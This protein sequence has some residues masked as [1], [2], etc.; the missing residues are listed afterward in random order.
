MLSQDVIR[1]MHVV[2]TE[3][4]LSSVD[5]KLKSIDRSYDQIVAGSTRAAS[6]TD[7]AHRRMVASF[8]RGG[9]GGVGGMVAGDATAFAARNIA[10]F[11]VAAGG[12]YAAIAAV[13]AV[14]ERGSELLEKYAN[15]QRSVDRAD[16]GGN[17][18]E[19]TK[20][21][22]DTISAE[23]VAR[24]TELGNRLA[25]AKFTI[26]QFLKVQLD[27]VDPALKLQ[28]AWVTIVEQI[29]AATTKLSGFVALI[30]NIPGAGNVGS[31]LLG[32]VPGGGALTLGSRVVN[33]LAGPTPAAPSQDESLAAARAR[34]GAAMGVRN[35]GIGED[36][37]AAR[38]GAP[39][40]TS[41]A[42]R[43]NAA[44][45]DLKNPAKDE[46]EEKVKRDEFDRVT[47]S[48]RKQ[49]EALNIQVETFGMS[50]TEAARYKIEQQLLNAATASG[51]ELTDAQRASIGATADAYARA[52]EQ[53]EQ[54]R[55]AQELSNEI[56]NA[57]R[58]GFKGFVSDITT[59]LREGAKFWDVFAEAGTKALQRISDKLM[60]MAINQLWEAAF[61]TKGD[62]GGGILGGLFG[63]G[64]AGSGSASIGMVGS[65]GGFA[66]P[67][68]MHDGGIVGVHGTTRG[69]V[70]P[71]Y[72]ENAPRYHKGGMAGL[73]PDE[74]PAVL[75]R[76]ERVI[77]RG[78]SMGGGTVVN[79]YDFR[80]ADPGSEARLRAML[81]RSE[82]RAVQRSVNEVPRV[83]S[84]NPKYMAGR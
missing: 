77:P 60:D 55:K 51:R 4:G 71:A 65:A 64:A 1:R 42:A 54:M 24:A 82:D 44:I 50:T 81:R 3:T 72:F 38:D 7:A 57:F 2:A 43:F 83:R 48:I 5:Q 13:N 16:L 23:Q 46:K 56:N 9:L 19:L 59:G 53:L 27:I 40:G 45:Y 74:V 32:A 29:A 11:I 8:N 49:T 37:Q 47:D 58:D 18:S 6:A 69:F 80:G 28:A 21:Q 17:L 63:S 70:H 79:N 33:G 75:Q 41:F 84:N 73:A 67:T 39:I 10:P 35:I 34:L 20:F 78:G 62:G 26:D 68:F 66:V 15:A 52:T 12:A 61:P 25:D 31:A 36:T 14:I 22:N 76:G 30:P